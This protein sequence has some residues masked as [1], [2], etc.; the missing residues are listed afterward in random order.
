MM[1]CFYATTN[2]Q[3]SS[4]TEAWME[5]AR[6]SLYVSPCRP[7]AAIADRTPS[8]RLRV[9]RLMSLRKSDTG[10]PRSRITTSKRTLHPITPVRLILAQ[11]SQRPK[12]TKEIEMVW[13]DTTSVGCAFVACAS[14]QVN[15][16]N[17]H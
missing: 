14:L 2:Q 17:T 1:Q 15:V 8:R 10:R 5:L 6:M 7:L 3:V 9:T 12:L 16:L 11:V 4:R 13:K